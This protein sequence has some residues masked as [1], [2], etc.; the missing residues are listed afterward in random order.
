MLIVVPSGWIS[1]WEREYFKNISHN[2]L[3]IRKSYLEE[4]GSFTDLYQPLERDGAANDYFIDN[5]VVLTSEESFNSR[6]MRKNIYNQYTPKEPGQKRPKKIERIRFVRV[7]IDEAH[8]IQHI[9]SVLTKNLMKL[10]ED[11]ASILFITGQPLATVTKSLFG[12]LKCWDTI[13]LAKQIGEPLTP[14]LIEIERGYKNTFRHMTAAEIS[15]KQD[16]V[17]SAKKE[18]NLKIQGLSQIMLKFGI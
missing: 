13:A 6:I 1:L 15:G 16:L 3:E 18:M 5:I 7:L 8:N 10:A 4:L 9:N 2:T 11:G 17:D 12:F 14:R